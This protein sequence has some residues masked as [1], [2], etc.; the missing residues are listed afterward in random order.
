MSIDLSIIRS[1]SEQIGNSDIENK[2][3]RSLEVSTAEPALIEALGR[4]LSLPGNSVEAEVLAPLIRREIHFRLLTAPHGAM[5]R[6][7]L[8]PGGHASKIA[9]AIKLIR[10]GYRAPLALPSLANA[11]G[12]SQSSFHAHFKSIT[13][14]TPL[15][16]QK[17][18]RMIEAKQ[19]LSEGAH[20]VTSAAFVVG[21]ESASQFS[22][23]YARKFGTSPKHDLLQTDEGEP[24][25][26]LT[27]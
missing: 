12:M 5:L 10:L 20:T 3:A 16:Y 17:D 24:W 23:E 13:G 25:R 19:L 1:L 8:S 18:L 2:H 9:K 26:Q 11:V 22:R 21:Y 27:S 7:L 15:Q 4:Y 14:T 6:N